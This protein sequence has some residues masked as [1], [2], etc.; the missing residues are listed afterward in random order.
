MKKRYTKCVFVRTGV[1]NLLL[2]TSSTYENGQI[3]CLIIILLVLVQLTV[4][5][6]EAVQAACGFEIR[7]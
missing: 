3:T 6:C 2:C 4:P 1:S 7:P 5:V